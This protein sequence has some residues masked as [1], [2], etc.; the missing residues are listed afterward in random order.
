[1]VSKNVKYGCFFGGLFLGGLAGALA[2]ILLAPKSGKELRSDLKHKGEEAVER[3]RKGYSEVQDRVKLVVGD[4]VQCVEKLKREAGGQFSGT[5]QKV[6]GIL[7]KEKAP[8][9]NEYSEEPGANA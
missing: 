2:G 8:V 7:S 4:A 3:A 9:F 5:Y 6:M 1:M